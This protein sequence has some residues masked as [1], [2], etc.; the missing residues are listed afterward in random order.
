[1][2][3]A[4]K[5][6]V[7]TDI[8]PVTSMTMMGV[9]REGGEEDAQQALGRFSAVYR[10]P[11]VRFAQSKG[12]TLDDAEDLVQGFFE[13]VLIRREA[14]K[15]LDAANWRLRRWLRVSLTRYIRNQYRNASRIKRGGHLRRT[16]F[17]EA[18][19]P[20]TDDAISLEF[21]RDWATAILN[22]VNA[23]LR[24]K[25]RTKGR[26]EYYDVLSTHIAWR[27]REAPQKELA[28]RFGTT[29]NAVKAQLKRIRD[30]YKEYLTEEVRETVLEDSEVREEIKH[31]FKVLAE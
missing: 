13:D 31:I 30:A 9:I 27:A 19:L 17:D 14:L 8:F 16:Q 25:F 18:K 23:R 11:L 10:G 7:P 3:I 5:E 12:A 21:D 4:D 29:Q 22:R 1:M 6:E 20:P 26:E 24:E 15:D 2:A 28:K